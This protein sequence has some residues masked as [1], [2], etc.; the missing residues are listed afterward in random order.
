MEIVIVVRG[1]RRCACEKSAAYSILNSV[2]AG[3]KE[4]GNSNP[5]IPATLLFFVWS[6]FSSFFLSFFLLAFRSFFTISFYF[7]IHFLSFISNYFRVLLIFS[8][9]SIFFSFYSFCDFA[10]FFP[11]YFLLFILFAFCTFIRFFSSFYSFFFFFGLSSLIIFILFDFSFLFHLLSFFL[12]F[13]ILLTFLSNTNIFVSWFA[14]IPL[15][16]LMSMRNTIITSISTE[17]TQY[18]PQRWRFVLLLALPKTVQ[19]LKLFPL[20]A[21]S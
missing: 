4:V 17:S 19:F 11:F 9:F 7:P 1:L 2:K 6:N 12:L 15:S 20:T 13:F 14:P 16:L 10:Y 8:I 21:D 5:D 18:L 3:R